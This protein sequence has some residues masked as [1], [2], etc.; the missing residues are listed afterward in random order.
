MNLPYYE[1][2]KDYPLSKYLESIDKKD[3]VYKTWKI[4]DIW[5]QGPSNGCTGYAAALLLES[6]PKPVK[7][8]PDPE[9]IFA[10]AR[11]ID[12]S[13]TKTGASIKGAL[14]ALQKLGFVKSYY[15]ADK[16]DEILIAVLNLGPVVVGIDFYSGMLK[17]TNGK[18]IAAGGVIGS[19]A[20]VVY[21]VDLEKQE[22]LVANSHGV[23]WGIHGTASVSV[24]TMNKI[25]KYGFAI[26]K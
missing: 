21:G 16:I 14:K 3:L 4:G 24:E 13:P 17:S 22:F 6:D 1:D 15:M 11:K 23:E 18:M 5:D 9:V 10:E 19:H 7:N 12:N 8:I 2:V 20:V 25:F 26:Q